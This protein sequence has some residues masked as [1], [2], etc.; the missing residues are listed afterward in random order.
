M[1]SRGDN[2][3]YYT[4]DDGTSNDQL[5]CRDLTDGST[6][7]LTSNLCAVNYIIPAEEQVIA[8]AVSRR[9]RNLTPY[10]FDKATNEAAGAL[11]LS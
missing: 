8:V 6:Y 2:V 3:L 1:Y 7:R 10:V 9:E 5:F 11:W 4:A